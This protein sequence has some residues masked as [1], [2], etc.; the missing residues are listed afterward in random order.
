MKQGEIFFVQFEP[1]VGFEIKKSRP[2][3]II[4]IEP[5]R[6]TVIVLPI[7]SKQKTSDSFEFTLKKSELNRLYLDSV[8]ILDQVKSFDRSRFIGKVGEI[9][10]SDRTKIL[11]KFNKLFED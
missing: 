11:S 8:V 5:Y 6:N 2:G 10:E 3:L 9:S 4:Q 7:S 1:S